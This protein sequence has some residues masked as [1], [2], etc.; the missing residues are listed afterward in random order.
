MKKFYSKG[1]AA[2]AFLLVMGTGMNAN[3]VVDMDENDGQVNF[4]TQ[5]EV[6]DTDGTAL[7]T[8]E[9]STVLD[10]D[11]EAGFSIGDGTT[12]YLRIDLTGC[13]FGAAVTADM[14]DFTDTSDEG[15]DA[16][17]SISQGGQADDDYVIVEVSATGDI[18]QDDVFSFMPDGS[19]EV[20]SQTDATISY[21]LYEF[22]SDALSETDALSD[23]TAD[24]FG[25]EDPLTVSCSALT[26]DKIDVVTPA[27]FVEFEG[28]VDTDLFT[29]TI[30]VDAETLNADGSVVA[31]T[32]YMGSGT[33]MTITGNFAAF[34]GGVTSDA[35][36][37]FTVNDVDD[38]FDSATATEGDGS[39]L[40]GVEDDILELQADGETDMVPGT[41]TVIVTPEEEEGVTLYELDPIDLGTCGTLQYSGS[42]DRMDF[43]LTPNG[44][45]SNYARITNPGDVSG[46][47]VMTVWDDAGNSAEFDIDAIEGVDSATMDAYASTDLIN[48][49]DIYA[50]AQAAEETFEVSTGEKMRIQVRGEFGDDAIDDDGATLGNVRRADGII[51]Q[52]L[53]VSTDSTSFFMTKN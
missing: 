26:A 45:F 51:I 8:G 30:D 14:F 18:V 22:A 7:A 33:E 20:T 28:D 1:A 47:V 53:T 23:T 4:A 46:A 48:V 43:A 24:Y 27:N 41:Y 11:V 21:S 9:G 17:F 52:G 12:K 40:I 32:D 19:I 34:D 38:A 6:D 50:A 29:Y 39:L 36:S 13:R 37:A 35:G 16:G 2:A 15:V 31:I 25:W 42:T 49:N 3:A 44:V 10:A 5:I